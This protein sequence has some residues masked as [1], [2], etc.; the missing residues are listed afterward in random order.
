MIFMQFT[1]GKY[2]KSDLHADFVCTFIFRTYGNTNIKKRLI[3][4]CDKDKSRTD[5]VGR[6]NNLHTWKRSRKL[7][8]P[9]VMYVNNDGTRDSSS[10]PSMFAFV[11]STIFTW[12]GSNDD[13]SR[14]MTK[15][16]TMSVRPEKTQISLGIRPV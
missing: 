3:R 14:D 11:I 8:V 1:R 13:M 2:G 15:P 10:E 4:F 7:K 6:L 16:Q 12:A 5:K 9:Y